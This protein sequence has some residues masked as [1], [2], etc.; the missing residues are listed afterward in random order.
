M[1]FYLDMHARQWPALGLPAHALVGLLEKL[2]YCLAVAGEAC[3]TA[4]D[5]QYSSAF[6]TQSTKSAQRNIY[7]L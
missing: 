2:L 3:Q 4:V 7:C 6:R 1:V 5:C